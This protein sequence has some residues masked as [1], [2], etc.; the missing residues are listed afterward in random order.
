M[1][2]EELKEVLQNLYHNIPIDYTRSCD[3]S[4]GIGHYEEDEE[5]WQYKLYKYITNLQHQL[6]QKR[7]I[8]KEAIEYINR[9]D[10]CIDIRDNDLNFISIN[11]LLEILNKEVK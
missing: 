2:K 6:E 3:S 8:R 1:N 9:E 5:S 11:E 4:D 7:N 10:I